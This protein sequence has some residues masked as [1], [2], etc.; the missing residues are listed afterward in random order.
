VALS[1]MGKSL[2]GEINQELIEKISNA[3]QG[4]TDQSLKE[5]INGLKKLNKLLEKMD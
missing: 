5:I 1:D 2:V 3:I 4:E